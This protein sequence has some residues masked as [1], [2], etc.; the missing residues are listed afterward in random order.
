M[1]NQL[2]YRADRGA[3]WH[4]R[5]RYTDRGE[6]TASCNSRTVLDGSAPRVPADVPAELRCTQGRPQ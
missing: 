3:K 5:W 2:V 4:R 1:T 6:V